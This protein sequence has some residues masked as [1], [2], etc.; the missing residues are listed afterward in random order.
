M[1]ELYM[2]SFEML[3]HANL[4]IKLRNYYFCFPNMHFLEHEKE[5]IL[6]QKKS[7]QQI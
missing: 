7:Y 5:F 6:I 1:T 2:P 3:R 4:K